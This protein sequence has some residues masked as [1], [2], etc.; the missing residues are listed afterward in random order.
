MFFSPC[1]LTPGRLLP[2]IGSR[3]D[4]ITA[5]AW[6]MQAGRR[7]GL[8]AAAAWDGS[9]SGALSVLTQTPQLPASPTHRKPALINILQP[10]REG[11]EGTPLR[12]Q[13]IP[14][15]VPR[16]NTVLFWDFRSFRSSWSSRSWDVSFRSYP[17]GGES[18]LGW[19]ACCLSSAHIWAGGTLCCTFCRLVAVIRSSQRKLG[20]AARTVR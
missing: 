15:R 9:W 19:P 5:A 11:G 8:S 12:G 2:L 3:G 6:E 7:S 17:S 16:T 13:S 14:P 18:S 1:S 20:V 10:G 4:D